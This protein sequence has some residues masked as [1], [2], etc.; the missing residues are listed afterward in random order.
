[1]LKDINI[2]KYLETNLHCVS[3]Q[4]NEAHQ[5]VLFI[6]FRKD[7]QAVLILIKNTHMHE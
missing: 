1:M 3:I 2:S 7:N 5:T 4:K 6:Q